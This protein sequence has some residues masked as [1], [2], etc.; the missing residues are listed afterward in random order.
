MKAS[1]SVTRPQS[2]SRPGGG[3][4]LVADQ[5]AA[6]PDRMFIPF[7][8][9]HN[10]VYDGVGTSQQ[11]CWRV[12]GW[13]VSTAADLSQRDWGRC[14]AVVTRSWQVRTCLF[15]RPARSRGDCVVLFCFVCSCFFGVFTPRSVTSHPPFSISRAAPAVQERTPA[16]ASADLRGCGGPS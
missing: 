10:P 14:V 16:H 12:H 7:E 1:A 8:K 4:L 9:E 11:T 15:D 3:V 13:R 5:C 6:R 2:W